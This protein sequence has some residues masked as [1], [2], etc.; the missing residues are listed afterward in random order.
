MKI[1][2]LTTGTLGDVRPFLA[3]ALGLKDAG[4]Q[5]TLVAPV[6]FTAYLSQFD[7]PYRTLVG[8]TQKILES[9]EG[10]RW[11]AS[12]N[13]KEFMNALSRIT[14]EMRHEVARDILA[15]CEDCDAMIVHALLLF[16]VA[17]LSEKLNKPFLLATPFPF[18]PATK[19]FPQF[20]VRAKRLPIGFLNRMTHRIFA[21]VYEKSKAGDINE[22]RA[23][24]GLT[25]LR[26]SLFDNLVSQ[27][28]PILQAYSPN[29]VTHP[30]DWGDHNYIT[31]SL[32]MDSRY[33]PESEKVKPQDDL[34]RWLDQGPPPIYFGFGS[35]PVLEPQK[36]VDMVV[37]ITKRL[38]VRAIL[39][40]GW[41]NLSS[42]GQTLPDSIFLIK[43]ADHVSLFPRCSCV[44]HHGGAGTTHTT[45]ESGTPSV[46]CSTYA[47]QPFWGER[48]TDLK[49]GRHIPFP[50][51]TTENMIQAIQELQHDDVKARAAEI[52][53]RMKAE[54]GLQNALAWIEKQLPSA[55]VYRN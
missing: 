32:K 45:L 30:K 37:D 2:L 20:L 22:W 23:Q 35:L 1:T 18:T 42:D 4:H 39:A 26:G 27:R 7:V 19:A 13:V 40:A 36:M 10:R 41:S 38:N 24:L 54:N 50:K 48:I 31:G 5:V 14:H 46:I 28:I 12:G 49:I 16:N 52:G 8:D 47:D 17:T 25:P 55:P 51:L 34:E 3:L 33:V 15:A 44:I 9:D 21:K 11:M 6:N 29:L 43:H 53:K